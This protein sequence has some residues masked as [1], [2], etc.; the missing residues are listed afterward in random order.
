MKSFN[1]FCPIFLRLNESLE[2]TTSACFISFAIAIDTIKWTEH[3]KQYFC[4]R[5][6][7]S[8]SHINW[9][10]NYLCLSLVSAKA[11]L[12]RHGLLNSLRPNNLFINF[13]SSDNLYL[14]LKESSFPLLFI[15]LNKWNT[16][17]KFHNTGMN[18]SYKL[19]G[20]N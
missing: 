5:S 12:E 1:N 2:V 9:S 11:L 7:Y 3:L 13:I 17:K 15:L 10:W 8:Y 6:S 4:S 20:L 19:E 16:L 14:S 18:K